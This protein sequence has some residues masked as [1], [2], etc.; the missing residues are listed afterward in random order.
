VGESEATAKTANQIIEFNSGVAPD[1]NGNVTNTS[2][3]YIRD[4]SIHPNPKRSLNIIQDGALGTQEVTVTGYFRAP[5][6][7][8]ASSLT[9]F[10]SWMTGKAT[11]AALPYGRFGLRLDDYTTMNLTPSAA[12]GYI[13]HDVYIERPEDSPDEVRFVAKFYKN[14]PTTPA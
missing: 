11:N 3:H 2:C 6:T 8:S 7:V 13:L 5:A 14:N 12:A 1:A 9:L 4:V 10:N